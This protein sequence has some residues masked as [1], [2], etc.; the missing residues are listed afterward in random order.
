M[1]DKLV[2]ESR[3][4]S[5]KGKKAARAERGETREGKKGDG[6]AAGGEEAVLNQETRGRK[7]ANGWG[8]QERP[9][10]CETDSGRKWSGGRCREI[11]RSPFEAKKN[12]KTATS[13]Q[14]RAN[15]WSSAGGANK[16]FLSSVSSLPSSD[17]ELFLYRVSNSG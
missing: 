2:V 11:D 8:S 6:R 13:W 3:P 7:P 10:L 5:Q 9:D 12:K 1:S 14:C 4:K 15:L 16:V 17:L